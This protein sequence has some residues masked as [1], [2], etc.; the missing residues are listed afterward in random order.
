M[1][2]YPEPDKPIQALP[3]DYTAIY[4]Q[5]LQVAYFLQISPHQNPVCNA[6]VP[7]MCPI[8]HLCLILLYLTPRIIQN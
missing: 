1:C 8:S 7:I 6:S 5:V 4:A 2:L 3:T